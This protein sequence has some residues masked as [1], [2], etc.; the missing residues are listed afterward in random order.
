MSAVEVNL[1]G[2][3]VAANTAV[4]YL[5]RDAANWKAGAVVVFRGRA[6]PEQVDVLLAALK[7][8]GLIPGQV[9]LKDLQDAFSGSCWD[10]EL[11][12][13]W[14]EVQEIVLTA[15]APTDERTFGEFAMAVAAV[16]AQGWNEAYVP[17]F[18]PEASERRALCQSGGG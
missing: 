18:H 13:P 7:D 5:Y 14:H 15:D 3:A 10:E 8:D 6:T 11:D 9:G 1:T 4:T 16:G 2:D 17:P 12:H